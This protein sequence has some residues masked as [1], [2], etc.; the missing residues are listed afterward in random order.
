MSYSYDA[1]GRM[2]SAS[3][4]GLSESSTYDAAGQR[5]QTSVTTG[6]TTY[7]TMVYDIFGQDVADYSGIS[8]TTL[9]SENI[10]RGGQLLARYN[11]GTSSLTYILTDV[12]GSARTVMNNSGGSSSVVARH[13]YLPFGEEIASGI[14][15]RTSGQG[16][17]ASD[18]NRQRYALTERDDAVG[19]DH[20][21]FRKYEN[22]SGRWTGPDALGGDIGDPQSFNRYA[23]VI[24]DPV[25]FI[26]PSGLDRTHGFWDRWNSFW[27]FSNGFDASVNGWD[28]VP[29][30]WTEFE[31]PVVFHFRFD[32]KQWIEYD[33]VDWGLV[34]PQKP[35]KQVFKQEGPCDQSR[36][37]INSGAQ[38]VANTIT[39]ARIGT[40]G[41]QTVIRFTGNYDQTVRQ[42]TQAGYYSGV[43]ANDPIYHPGGTEFRTYGSPG[44][45]FNLLFPK[46]EMAPA[47][48]RGGVALKP[49]SD[50]AVAT[51]L[52][53]D[54][55][56]PVGAGW[57]ERLKHGQDFMN[58]LPWWARVVIGVP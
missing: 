32:D 47:H 40:Q 38:Q 57:K 5:V 46:L 2:T 3:Q 14:G 53:I 37:A 20:T 11:A 21:W 33:S 51:D 23:Y 26:D 58:G 52:H 54:C 48:V 4:T 31:K 8:G 25:N 15:L 45:H 19:L 16:Y 43:W 36:A 24:N 9:E 34:T 56:N 17:G 22:L 44:F 13:D 55:H 1:N 29:S 30:V 39:G 27:F 18:T 35:Q 41:G 7:R 42:L 50:P 6:S 49:S 12:Q 28:Q 10:Y